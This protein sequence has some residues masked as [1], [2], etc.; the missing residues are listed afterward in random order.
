MQ[1]GLKRREFLKLASA[2][3]VLPFCI[4]GN[5]LFGAAPQVSKL[6]SPGC[7]T[8][9][10]KVARIYIANP[11]GLWPKPN[12]DLGS[13]VK[14]YQARFAELE[15]QLSDVDFIVDEL[16][17]T[18]EQALEVR[19]KAQGADGLLVV[20]LTLG[21]RPILAE[22]LKLDLPTMIFAAPYSGH[23]WAGFGELQK[24]ITG[25]KMDCI[26]SSDYRQLATAIRPFRA[27]HHLREA[28][29]LNNTN[30][31]STDYAEAVMGKFGTKIR[32]IGL[33]RM[34]DSYNSVDIREARAEA[35]RWIK[36]AT[37]VREPSREEIVRSCRLALALQNLLDEE[38]ATVM[39]VDCYGSMYR[40]LPAFPCI[41]FTR[42][43]DLGLGGICESD[44]ECALTHILFQGLSG[45]PGFISDPTLDQS[46]NSIILAHCLGSTK[47]DG[48]G[49]PAC[50]YRIR[51][52]ME[53]QEGA[54]TQVKMSTGRK[55]TQ[56][57]LVGTDQVLYFTGEVTEAPDLDRGCRTKITVRLDG[58]A[59]KL[60]KNWT[61]GLHRVTVYEDVSKDLE[62]FCRFNDLR[63]V[64][65]AV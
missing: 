48:P 9:K 42:L 56:A 1:S 22:V 8:S 30:D 10:V 13:E 28:V 26:L 36:G 64:N 63:L 54:V 4:S 32:I 37:E 40:K 55:V 6:V 43:N 12:L 17:T 33:Q 62:R 44:L 35:D 21:I 51:T 3:A 47:M 20:H 59:E 5:F 23:E 27:I 19:N 49:G 29:I 58:D 61:N 16:V 11:E 52:I 53:R 57:R 7:R 34:L 38:N 65:E 24:Q 45:K 14:F 60:W 39:S 2:S 18:P 46:T 31:P 25:A 50:P 15:D 41:G